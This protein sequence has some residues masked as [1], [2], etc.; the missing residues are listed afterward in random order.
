MRAT[1]TKLKTQKEES[2]RRISFT[3]EFTNT[4]HKRALP[5]VKIILNF[6]L[7]YRPIF[8]MNKILVRKTQK[9]DDLGSY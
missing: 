9:I 6:S 8:E 2:K 7:K 1:S 5:F 3:N 4:K